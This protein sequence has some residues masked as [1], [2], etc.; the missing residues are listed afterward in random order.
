MRTEFLSLTKLRSLM[1][2][3]II[4]RQRQ[5]SRDTTYLGMATSRTKGRN[6]VDFL[7]SREQPGVDDVVAGWSRGSHA[8]HSDS[9]LWIMEFCK[10]IQYTARGKYLQNCNVCWCFLYYKA[11]HWYVPRSIPPRGAYIDEVMTQV[12][13][14][15][16]RPEYKL[17][18]R[19]DGIGIFLL[20]NYA[21]R[22]LCNTKRKES[23]LHSN[24]FQKT[25]YICRACISMYTHIHRDKWT[26][27][28]EWKWIITREEM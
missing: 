3:G 15:Y 11:L 14:A 4:F 1:L 26:G 28:R 20:G 24:L 2:V 5:P 23:F 17:H 18:H 13:Y 9:V 21:V 22:K 10:Q 8:G 6:E 16:F 12:Q 25:Q 27:S 7:I 19:A